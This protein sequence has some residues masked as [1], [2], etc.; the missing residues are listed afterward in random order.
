VGF[1]AGP[2]W[3]APIAA[4]ETAAAIAEATIVAVFISVS[5][6]VRAEDHVSNIGRH[7]L[8]DHA[9]RSVSRK[10]AGGRPET[11][12]P[13]RHRIDTVHASIYSGRRFHRLPMPSE[14]CRCWQEPTE[15]ARRRS[16]EVEDQRKSAMRTSG[17]V[18][19]RR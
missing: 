2:A 5:F 11:E 3:A 7:S 9:D 12:M 6:R 16:G 17:Y 18:R 19:Y 1:A 8:L 4:S 13:E 14:R 10:D 15:S